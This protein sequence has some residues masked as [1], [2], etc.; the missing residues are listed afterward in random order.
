MAGVDHDA[1]VEVVFRI[2]RDEM[3]A[4]MV[5]IWDNLAQMFFAERDWS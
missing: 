3:F 4:G 1:S 5:Q 2:D